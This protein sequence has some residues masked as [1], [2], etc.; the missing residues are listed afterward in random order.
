MGAADHLVQDVVAAARSLGDQAARDAADVLE[1]WDRTTDAGSRGAVLFSV[2][3]RML[4][5]QRWPT[6]SMFELPWSPQA[7]LATPDG[8]ADARIAVDLLERAAERV[9]EMYGSLDVPWGEVHLLNAEP[10]IPANGG[11]GEFGIFRVVGFEPMPDDS[12]R[13]VATSGD[14]F[15]AAVEF[16]QPVR[17]RVVTTYGNA[18][19]PGS[20]HRGDQLQLFAGKR[21]REAWLTR[22][23]VMQ[24][25]SLR[26]LF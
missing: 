3:F 16:S 19:Q 8:L 13:F 5:Q 1:A 12:T 11:G 26:E 23:A 15:V 20:P 24:N 22:A 2:Y 17:A 21:M 10:A 18:S 7:P 25:L 4:Q 14:S 6:G 9:R